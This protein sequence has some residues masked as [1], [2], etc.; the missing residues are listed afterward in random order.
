MKITEIKT[1][2]VN[3]QMRNRI[4]VK[5]ETDQPGLWGWREEML[6][7][8]VRAVVRRV[9]DF[10]PTRAYLWG[11]EK[12][13]FTTPQ[14]KTTPMP[15]QKCSVIEGPQG[16]CRWEDL[17]D[18][19]CR[20]TELN[21]RRQPFQGCALPPELPRHGFSLSNGFE[22]LSRKRRAD[23]WNEGADKLPGT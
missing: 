18:R 9:E 16:G 7:G 21:R 22:L 23:G 17:L 5:V 15:S 6:E 3:A 10:K 2:V 19:W 14:S 1:L 12:L 13:P 4:F 11:R 20:G 8:K